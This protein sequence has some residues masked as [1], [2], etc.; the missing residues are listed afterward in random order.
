MNVLDRGVLHLHVPSSG[1]PLKLLPVKQPAKR[2]TNQRIDRAVLERRFPLDSLITVC[3]TEREG[4]E[5]IAMAKPWD[6]S[7]KKLVQADPQAFVIWFVPDAS[8]TGARPHELKHWTLEVDALL[9]VQ[10][11]GQDMLLHLEFQ[12]HNDP[13]M[14]ERLLR[15]NVLARSEHRLPVLSCVIYLLG[16]G[17]V[18]TSPLSWMLPTEQEVLRFHYQSIE[19]KALLPE[20]VIRTGLTGLLPLLPLTK[21]GARREIVETMFSRLLAAKKVDLVPIG[22]TLASLAFSREN[23]VDQDWLFR[24]FHEMHDILRETPIYQ[25]ILKEGSLRRYARRSSKSWWNAFPS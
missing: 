19:L 5:T 20:E 1:G 10:V 13:G 8:F 21:N 6:D 16:N 4:R 18:S 24:R 11:K 22:Y 12:T 25:E 9:G 15:Y 14:A 23:P 17:E 3:Y 2:N 7:L